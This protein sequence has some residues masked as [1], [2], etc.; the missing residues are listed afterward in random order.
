LVNADGTNI[1]ISWPINGSDNAMLQ[2]S[3][4]FIHWTNCEVTVVPL[5]TNNTVTIAPNDSK[6]FYRLI[7]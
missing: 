7:R 4:D 2:E 6:E 1:V 3:S 5:G